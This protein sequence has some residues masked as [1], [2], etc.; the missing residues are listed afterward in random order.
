MERNLMILPRI[1]ER[2]GLAPRDGVEPPT[3][4]YTVCF[5]YVES[6][7]KDPRKASCVAHDEDI[8]LDVPGEVVLFRP[9]DQCL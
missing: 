1:W 7:H 5:R 9:I 8:V 6:G 4:R 3:R 2:E